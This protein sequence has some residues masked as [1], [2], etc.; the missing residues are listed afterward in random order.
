MVSLVGKF[1]PF[2]KENIRNLNAAFPIRDLDTLAGA[3]NL[4]ATSSKTFFNGS[5]AHA[6]MLH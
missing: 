3:N 2:R 6:R 1:S 5:A 4:A